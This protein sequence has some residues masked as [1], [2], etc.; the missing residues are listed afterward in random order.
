ME[1]LVDNDILFKA[2]MYGLLHE[3]LGPYNT[4]TDALG[5]L[6]AAQFV[7]AKKIR[8]QSPGTT[9]T[10]EKLDQFFNFMK[11]CYVLE[12]TDEE[13]AMA[14]DFEFAAQRAA[15]ALDSGE[16]QLCAVLVQRA[17]PV[18]L[19]G[20][21]RA[22]HAIQALLR[23]DTRLLTLYGKV[24]CLEQLFLRSITE[25]SKSPLRAA[26][27]REPDLDKAITICFSCK[28]RDPQLSNIIAGLQSYIND[29]RT[30]ASLVLAA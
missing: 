29:L 8:K 24:V 4:S 28:G 13:Q 2:L 30:K 25:A 10:A 22:I 23:T 17:V 26:V 9:V 3:L 16:S 20:D 11:G 14:A 12:P 18:L 6:G 7:I 21:K 19:T 27:C 15:V 1:A 5:V